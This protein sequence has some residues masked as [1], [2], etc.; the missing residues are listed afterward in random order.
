MIKHRTVGVYIIESMLTHYSYI[1]S[2]KN[3][4]FRISQH[5]YQLKKMTSGHTKLQEHVNI[6]G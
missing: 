6:Y 2:S 5:K 1:G 4:G 3:V